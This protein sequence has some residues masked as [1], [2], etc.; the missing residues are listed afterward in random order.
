MDSAYTL[1]AKLPAD[2]VHPKNALVCGK[3]SF[4]EVDN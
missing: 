4:Q 2:S 3:T 1:L